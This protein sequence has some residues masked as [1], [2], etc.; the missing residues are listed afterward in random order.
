VTP[1][2]TGKAKAGTAT[3]VSSAAA[4]IDLSNQLKL[5]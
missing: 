1:T 2:V 4:K 3:E 5:I